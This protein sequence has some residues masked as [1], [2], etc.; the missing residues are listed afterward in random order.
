MDDIITDIVKNIFEKL[1]IYKIVYVF[2]LIEI[3]YFMVNS[4]DYYIVNIINLLGFNNYVCL[5][6]EAV[7]YNHIILNKIEY[8]STAIVYF[9]GILCVSGIIIALLKLIP[10]IGDNDIVIKYSGC[11]LFL[12]ICFILIYFIYFVFR[13][14]HLIFILLIPLIAI[15]VNILKKV[16]RNKIHKYI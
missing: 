13:F 2:L 7:F 12:G 8:W 10:V 11:G 5:P 1:N 6:K 9:G 4:I 15:S 14:N 16:I 3:Y